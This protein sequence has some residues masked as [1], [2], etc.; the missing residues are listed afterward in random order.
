MEPDKIR[1]VTFAVLGL[2]ALRTITHAARIKRDAEEARK[3]DLESE[4][5]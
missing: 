3:R 1:L 4:R 2:L 5:E